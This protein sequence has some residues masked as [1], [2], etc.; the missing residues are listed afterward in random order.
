[1]QGSA[2]GTIRY[3][4]GTVDHA[5]TDPEKQL[6]FADGYLAP[7]ME[8]NWE[9]FQCP[10]FGPAQVDR[11]R[12]GRMACGYGYNG[13]YLGPGVYYDY[14]AWPTVRVAARPVA[15]RFRDVAQLTQT[16]T[17]ADSAVYNT[18]TYSPGQFIENWLL[19][20]PSRTQPTVHFRH[21]DT[22][23]VAFLDGH[24][25]TRSKSWIDLPFWFTPQD[26]QA[27][28]ENNLG[29]IGEDDGLYDRE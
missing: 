18:W 21:L 27:N 26:I 9:A 28:Q 12:F 11:V 14:S 3:W 5:Q 6:D 1:G 13:H 22:A 4:F 17:F 8:A 23:N 25:E 20:P 29:F 7:Y 15:Y 16:I 10:N 2:R 24:V 19:E